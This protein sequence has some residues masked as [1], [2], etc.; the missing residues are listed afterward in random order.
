MFYSFWM[1]FLPWHGIPSCLRSIF[2]S[3][4]PARAIP[5]NIVISADQQVSARLFGA[6]DP[7]DGNDAATHLQPQLG[8]NSNWT[9]PSSQSPRQDAVPK[10][11]RRR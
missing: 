3:R 2:Q 6:N 5:S 4:N 8:E 11:Q 7:P 1:N 9:P 10:V